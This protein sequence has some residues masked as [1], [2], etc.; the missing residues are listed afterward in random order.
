MK[1]FGLLRFDLSRLDY[2]IILRHA[3]LATTYY[4]TVDGVWTHVGYRIG[5]GCGDGSGAMQ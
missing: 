1:V 5:F 4:L 2:L 3:L